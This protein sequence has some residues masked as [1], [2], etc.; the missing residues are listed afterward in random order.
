MPWWSWVLIWTFLV[1]ALLGMLAYFAWWLF[2]KAMVVLEALGELSG[3][4]ELLDAASDEVSP[5]HFTPAVLRDRAEVR[6][7]H[8]LLRELQEE[9]KNSRRESRMARG[10]LL[11]TADL[12]KRTFPWESSATRSGGHT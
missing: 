9:R 5:Y 1:L 2:K 10:K 8:R 6:E 7:A 11:V 4:L 12:R 3:K